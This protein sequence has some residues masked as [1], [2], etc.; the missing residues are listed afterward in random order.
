M[1]EKTEK[2]INTKMKKIDEL[3]LSRKE[4]LEAWKNVKA[5]KSKDGRPFPKISQ[6]FTGCKISKNDEGIKGN[7]TM[8]VYSTNNAGKTTKYSIQLTKLVD[9]ENEYLLKC[10]P[11]ERIL[12]NSFGKPTIIKDIDE[13]WDI[14]TNTKLNIEAQIFDLER[15]REK[16][17]LIFKKT[18]K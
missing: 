12:Y 15:I 17:L 2:I 14:I 8:N 18:E 5:V 3:I 11:E 4:A 9:R 10:L 16:A 1:T 7:Y 6:N 13:I